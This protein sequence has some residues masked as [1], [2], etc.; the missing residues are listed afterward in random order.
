MIIYRRFAVR[1]YEYGGSGIV[2][3]LG[4]LLARYLT[5]AMLSTAA[6]AALRGCLDAAKR[7]VPHLLAHKLVTSIAK[8]RKGLEKVVAGSQEP[9]SKE[10]SVDTGGIDITALIDGAGI[11]LIGKSIL[12][13]HKG[14]VV[15]E[16]IKS[17][18][19]DEYQPITGT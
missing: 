11:V 7:A 2:D 18:E 9:Q 15:D 12:Q 4:S 17:Y 13:L 10:A 16:S 19:Y 3:T 14:N 1:R 6:R 5:K 8:K